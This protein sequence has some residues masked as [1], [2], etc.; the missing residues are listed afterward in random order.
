M[1]PHD[2]PAGRIPD[3][4]DDDDACD[5]DV[6]AEGTLL[7]AGA[8]SMTATR[9]CWMV[10]SKR[11]LPGPDATRRLLRGF[12]VVRMFLRSTPTPV[13]R[14]E[15]TPRSSIYRFPFGDNWLVWTKYGRSGV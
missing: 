10:F 13:A 14:F 12:P 15:L 8:D 1:G 7:I 5:R 6:E 4:D 9:Q 11:R 2:A 3:D